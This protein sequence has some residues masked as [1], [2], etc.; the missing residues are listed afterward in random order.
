[1]SRHVEIWGHIVDQN[2]FLRRVAGAALVLAFVALAA[3]SYGLLVGLY[4]PLAFVVSGSGEAQFLGRLREREAPGDAEIGHVAKT[5]LRR[6]LGFSSA[7]VES[8]FA[9]AWNLM[10][11][12]MQREQDQVLAAYAKD[13]QQEFV[14]HIQAQGIQTLIDFDDKR[15][16]I[17]AKN[18]KT[19]T[20]RLVGRARTWPLQLVGEDQTSDKDFE[21]FLTLVRCPR[22]EMTP[23]G[24]L[25]AKFSVR[26]TASQPET[27]PSP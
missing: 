6:F 13:N 4:Q 3:G 10:T 8:D 26:F 25:V 17:G 21:A 23:N 24:L 11:A 16:Q 1:V 27:E 12:Q 9:E 18:G 22:T 20:V 15:T 2:R 14:A 19:F 7:T 5:F